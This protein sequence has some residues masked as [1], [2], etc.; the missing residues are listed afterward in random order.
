[1]EV[2]EEEVEA[3]RVEGVELFFITNN[4]VAEAVYYRVKSR[5]KDIFDLMLQLVYLY[6]SVY[7]RLHIIWVAG[8]R[9]I[10]AVIYGFSS[11][12]LTDGTALPSSILDFMP[13]NSTAFERS[14]SILPWVQTWIGVNNIETLSPE[15]W[16]EDDNGLKRGK[17]NENGIW[18]PYHSKGKLFVGARP[19]SGRIVVEPIRA[20]FAQTFQHLAYFYLS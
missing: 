7:F 16:F 19:F 17:K 20:G 5:D 13:L 4:S 2:V 12:C 1:M 6:L 18:I 9:K 8:K 11:D 15:G 10:A 14:V 3:G